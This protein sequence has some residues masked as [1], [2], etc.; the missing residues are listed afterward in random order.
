MIQWLIDWLGKSYACRFALG[1]AS[2]SHK[3]PNIP[4]PQSS[5]WLTLPTG[6]W[7]HTLPNLQSSWKKK[8]NRKTE[9]HIVSVVINSIGRS[10][11]PF[12]HS[13]NTDMLMEVNGQILNSSNHGIV[14]YEDEETWTY[15]S[16]AT[17]VFA[18]AELRNLAR[19]VY[20]S[21][22][23]IAPV[24]PW[25]IIGAARVPFPGQP[26][27]GCYFISR[28]V[29]GIGRRPEFP[30]RLMGWASFR[31]TKSVP[32]QA[33]GIHIRRETIRAVLHATDP[34]LAHLR[35]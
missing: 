9:C 32:C 7:P 2:T 35:P 10:L 8:R 26:R 25:L 33:L 19:K 1:E 5:H 28:E 34:Y 29:V 21:L 11:T 23:N 18:S 27:L 4:N 12:S 13:S 17:T 30:P 3:Y 24:I 15:A 6:H 16:T 31:T 22:K 20:F 14:R